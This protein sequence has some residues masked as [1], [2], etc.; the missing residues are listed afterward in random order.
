MTEHPSPQKIGLATVTS[1][2]FLPGTVV[3]LSSFL[4]HN[5]WFSGDIF[6]IHENLSDAGIKLLG[7]AFPNVI[8]HALS[9]PMALRLDALAEAVPWMSSRRLQFG[10]LEILSFAD[11]DRVLFF[12]SDLLFLASIAE[13]LALPDALICCGDGAFYRGNIRSHDDFSESRASAAADGQLRESFNS[14]FM[15]LGKPLLSENIYDSAL[16]MITADRWQA[17]ATGHTDQMLFNLLFAGQQTLVSPEYNFAL[18]HREIIQQSKGVFLQD[19]KVVH[20][21]GP[22]KPWLVNEILHRAHVDPALIAAFQMWHDGFVAFLTRRK[23]RA[24]ARR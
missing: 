21:A 16:S 19:A 12:D 18:S 14:G 10:S 17:D 5:R 24:I 15:I 20:F 11:L 2:D 1:E 7:D 23:L 9:D 3:M 8:L 4:A 6:V 22:A 13:L